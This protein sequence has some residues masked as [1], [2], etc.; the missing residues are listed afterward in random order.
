MRP[1]GMPMCVWRYVRPL[2]CAALLAAHTAGDTGLH[3]HGIDAALQPG[4]AQDT[5]L[6]G[7][8]GSFALLK[9][10]TEQAAPLRPSRS[11]ISI[12]REFE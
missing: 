6:R 3:H 12:A 9:T 4:A 11:P 10:E 5:E 7:D 2:V 1:I 8:T